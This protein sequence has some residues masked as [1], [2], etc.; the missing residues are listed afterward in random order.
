MKKSKLVLLLFCNEGQER[1][2]HGCSFVKGDKSYL[3]LG[4]KRGGNVKNCQKHTKNYSFL[5]AI[6]LNHERITDVTLF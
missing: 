4:I 1:I 2:A 3:L 5:R 6:S